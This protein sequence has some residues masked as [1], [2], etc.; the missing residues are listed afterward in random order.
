[1]YDNIFKIDY[2]TL[3]VQLLPTNRRKPVNIAFVKVLAFPFILILNELRSYR[4]KTIYRLQHDS[5]IGKI[6]KLLNDT[7]DI[8]DKSIRIVG[9]KRGSQ[10]YSYYL[11]ENRPQLTTPIYTYYGNEQLAFQ[12][13]F[14][15]IIPNTL[16]ITE[17]DRI[18]MDRLV[19]EYA[20]KDKTFTITQE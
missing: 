11:D 17:S 9:K 8:A 4:E 19:R 16:L 2:N 15:V 12:V 3:A 5:R 10:N 6:E 20:D 13:D 14:E 1:M 18:R 7:F